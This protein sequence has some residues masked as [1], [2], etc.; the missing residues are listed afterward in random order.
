M[1]NFKESDYFFSRV[2][3]FAPGWKRSDRNSIMP[4]TATEWFKHSS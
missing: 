2:E 4:L 1:L 3:I